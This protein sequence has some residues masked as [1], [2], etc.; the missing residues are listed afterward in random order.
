MIGVGTAFLSE[1]SIG[2]TISLNQDRFTVLT[3]DDDL[4]ITLD[5]ASDITIEDE[6]GRVDDPLFL[7]LRLV[8]ADPNHTGP[9]EGKFPNYVNDSTI[10]S[11]NALGRTVDNTPSGTWITTGIR[12][13]S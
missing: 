4:T 11:A 1:V 5:S 6:T 13:A 10:V 3:V 9:V 7:E 8:F 2:D 12:S